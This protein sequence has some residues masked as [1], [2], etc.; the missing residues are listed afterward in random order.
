MT[1]VRSRSQS[2]GVWRARLRRSV[3]QWEEEH[4]HGPVPVDV[5]A[6]TIELE[7]ISSTVEIDLQAGMHFLAVGTD[8]VTV[9]LDADPEHGGKGLGF[10]PLEL[11]LIGLGACTGMDVVSIL[12]KKRQHLTRYLV[13][14][15]AA[16]AHTHPHV[17]TS[18]HIRH[19][20]EGDNVQE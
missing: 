12:R 1:H 16:Q 11:L 5:D 19:I 7:R 3:A 9:S 17:F 20:L 2:G 10:R 8:G 15:S 14:V 6:M 4:T 18:V 13:E